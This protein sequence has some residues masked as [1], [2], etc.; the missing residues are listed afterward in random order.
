[1]TKSKLVYFDMVTYDYFVTIVKYADVYH[2]YS[3]IIYACVQ[4]FIKTVEH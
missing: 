3:V 2:E 1:M 4:Y